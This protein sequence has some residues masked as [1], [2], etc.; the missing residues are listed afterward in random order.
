MKYG[1]TE[2]MNDN[3]QSRKKKKNGHG[4]S[5]GDDHV[6]LYLPYTITL[7][8]QKY[9]SYFTPLSEFQFIFIP[10]MDG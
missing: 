7:P 1:K 3:I 5:E 4:L 8:P 2:N 6:L 9:S 10:W